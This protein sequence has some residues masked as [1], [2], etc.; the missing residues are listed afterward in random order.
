M[1]IKEFD[2]FTEYKRGFPTFKTPNNGL[3]LLLF[4]DSYFGLSPLHQN[5]VPDDERL[6][7]TCSEQILDLVPRDEIQHLPVPRLP[8]F[9]IGLCSKF[10]ESNDCMARIAVEQLMDGMDLDDDWIARN[11]GDTT[12]KVRELATQLVAEK[13]LRYAEN[14]GLEAAL[15]ELGVSRMQDLSSIPGSGF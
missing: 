1:E 11:L 8:A 2:L 14:M 15:P 9:F 5:I 12:V 13:T 7:T 4:S 3:R 6:S 10:F